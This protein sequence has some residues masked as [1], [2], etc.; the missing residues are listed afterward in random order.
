VTFDSMR[1]IYRTAL[2]DGV[3]ERIFSPLIRTADDLAVSGRHIFTAGD[4]VVRY[5]LDGAEPVVLS[6]HQSRNVTVDGAH[7][8]WAEI[9]DYTT[10]AI[11]RARLDES[12]STVLTS[13]RFSPHALAVGPAHVYW[14][15]QDDH[16]SLLAYVKK[17]AK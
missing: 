15:E 6:T 4:G 7:V 1:G 3:P 17:I 5:S 13:T 12:F 16:I 14:L 10:G 8:Y 9:I 2:P 11:R